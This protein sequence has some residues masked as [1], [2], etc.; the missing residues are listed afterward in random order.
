MTMT[1]DK[2]LEIIKSGIKYGFKDAQARDEILDDLR[3]H[4]RRARDE[5]IDA[6]ETMGVH[7]VPRTLAEVQTVHF[8]ILR[9]YPTFSGVQHLCNLYA[10]VAKAEIKTL[11]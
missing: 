10:L 2:M 4:Y 9:D 5:T 7:P 8:D 11:N 1:N 3:Y 6:W